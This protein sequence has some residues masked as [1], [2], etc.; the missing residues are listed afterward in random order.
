VENS[1]QLSER[2]SIVAASTTASCTAVVVVM[3]V[4][5]ADLVVVASGTAGV[6]VAR[7]DGTAV[8]AVSS[9]SVERAGGVAAL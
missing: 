9:G 6:V 5:V 2:V 8:D 1:F 4:V 7:I 3:V